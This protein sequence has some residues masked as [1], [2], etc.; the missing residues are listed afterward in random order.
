MKESVRHKDKAF[1]LHLSV[2]FRFIS[3]ICSRKS[4]QFEF[5]QSTNLSILNYMEV[6]TPNVKISQYHSSRLACKISLE[7]R[8]NIIS[9]VLKYYALEENRNILWI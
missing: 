8:N 2:P 6:P 7:L 9:M 3:E 1:S 5:S 4:N